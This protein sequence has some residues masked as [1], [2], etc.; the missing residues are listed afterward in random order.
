MASNTSA[1]HS[2]S[3]T[4]TQTTTESKRRRMS[5]R[6]QPSMTAAGTSTSSV[7]SDPHTA[8]LQGHDHEGLI[9]RSRYLN[10]AN[11]DPE[12]D[13]FMK[14]TASKNLEKMITPYLTHHIPQQYNPLGALSQ[15]AAP[16]H[17]N[18]KYCYRHRPDIS[19][20]CIPSTFISPASIPQS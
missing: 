8:L 6:A 3:H 12:E 19:K 17:A 15:H 2:L 9:D 7:P 20:I 16:S 5:W 11:N 4:H 10:E 18:T 1:T 13:P 14:A